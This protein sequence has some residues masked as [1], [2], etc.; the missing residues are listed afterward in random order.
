M[1]KL[2]NTFIDSVSTGPP[3]HPT[4]FQI[5]E[6]SAIMGRHIDEEILHP[7]GILR[8]IHYPLYISQAITNASHTQKKDAHNSPYIITNR[9]DNSE[10]VI[11]ENN[12][13]RKG[14]YQNKR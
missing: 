10:N 1:N 5:R 6:E 11:V 13:H 12:K 7:I 2:M 8:E 4:A 9:Q 14:I 3:G